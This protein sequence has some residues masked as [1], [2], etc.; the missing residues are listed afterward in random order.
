[1]SQYFLVLACVEN[2]VLAIYGKNKIC[3]N[4]GCNTQ[5]LSLGDFMSIN[6]KEIVKLFKAH[7]REKNDGMLITLNPMIH[8]LDIFG[9]TI[10]NLVC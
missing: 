1:M 6:L 10:A 3:G 2:M 9:F 4:K 8:G 7:G 5:L